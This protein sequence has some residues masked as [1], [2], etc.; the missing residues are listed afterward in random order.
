MESGNDFLAGKAAGTSRRMA[1]QARQ[2]PVKKVSLDIWSLP[3]QPS[4][5]VFEMFFERVC[6]Y[7]CHPDENRR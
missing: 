6:D 2:R 1:S 7:A 3:K 4:Q 5:E